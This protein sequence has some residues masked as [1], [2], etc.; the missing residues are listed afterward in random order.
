M[1][2]LSL[3][4]EGLLKLSKIKNENTMTYPGL[5]ANCEFTP[6]KRHFSHSNR[7]NRIN[8]REDYQGSLEMENIGI[9]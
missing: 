9:K 7:E 8:G 1:W 4:L 3:F 5:S 6:C 2:E